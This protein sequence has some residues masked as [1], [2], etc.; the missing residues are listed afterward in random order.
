VLEILG[1]DAVTAFLIIG[2]VGLGVV[3][4]SLLL[5]E[6]LGGVFETFDADAGGG[7]LSG[8]VIG[9]FL[10]AFGFGAALV[11]YATGI[12]AA[13]GALSGLASGLV[14]GGLALWMMRSL[15]QMPTDAPV[16]TGDLVGRT[17]TVVTRIPADGLG[18]VTLSHS[19]Q[20]MKLSARAAQPIPAGTTVVVTTVL[21][22][23]SVLVRPADS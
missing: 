3:L 14:I 13:G 19:G 2:A 1:M 5:G 11:M 9:S 15:I 4:L 12:G 8:P 22:S 16:R 20:L 21:S 17:A 10:A 18:E 7:L 6:V 23:S